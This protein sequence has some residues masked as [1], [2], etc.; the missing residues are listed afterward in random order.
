MDVGLSA[1]A[2][3]RATSGARQKSNSASLKSF[4]ELLKAS[5]LHDSAV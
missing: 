5:N 1:I 3:E 4:V 2:T